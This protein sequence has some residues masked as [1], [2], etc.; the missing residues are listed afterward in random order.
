[1]NL[2]EDIRN[3]IDSINRDYGDGWIHSKRCVYIENSN[4]AIIEWCCASDCEF[5]RR[6]RER[7]HKVW[8]WHDDGRPLD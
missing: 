2:H 1:M 6:E 5:S 7:K 4:G 8:P 3:T